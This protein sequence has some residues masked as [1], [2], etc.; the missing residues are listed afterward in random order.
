LTDSDLPSPIIDSLTKLLASLAR[1]S[2]LKRQSKVSSNVA[3]IQKALKTKIIISRFNKPQI[4]H[5]NPL[6]AKKKLDAINSENE[7]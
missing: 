7:K 6:I 5:S 2:S 4:A 1:L 3:N